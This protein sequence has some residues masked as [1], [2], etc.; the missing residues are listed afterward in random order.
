M[1][2]GTESRTVRTD[3]NQPKGLGR[4]LV[5]VVAGACDGSIRIEAAEGGGGLRPHDAVLRARINAEATLAYEKA[6]TA[7]AC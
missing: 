2:T 4:I 3:D 1:A 6:M 7:T 5:C